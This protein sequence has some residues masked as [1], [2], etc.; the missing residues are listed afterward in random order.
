MSRR[1]TSN[2]RRAAAAETKKAAHERSGSD[3]DYADVNDNMGSGVFIVQKAPRLTRDATA[4]S[5]RKLLEDFLLMSKPLLPVK[6]TG[7]F[8]KSKNQKTYVGV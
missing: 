5:V 3:T 1:K 6:L 4:K 8:V 7:V 2:S